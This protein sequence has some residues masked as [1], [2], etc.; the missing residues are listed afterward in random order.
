MSGF[1]HDLT[2]CSGNWHRK[3]RSVFS[4]PSPGAAQSS[5]A[6]RPTFH[7]TPTEGTISSRGPTTNPGSESRAKDKDL[8]LLHGASLGY[9][10]PRCVVSRMALDRSPLG[11]PRVE[12]GNGEVSGGPGPVPFSSVACR[13]PSIPQTQAKLSSL[14]RPRSSLHHACAEQA[15]STPEG[16]TKAH[17]CF[18]ESPWIRNWPS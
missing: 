5:H 6:H 3:K 9:P 11:Q 18:R 8:G 7:L 17:L 13:G 4:T 10:A 12:R 2:T 15:C 14:A 1:T 16:C